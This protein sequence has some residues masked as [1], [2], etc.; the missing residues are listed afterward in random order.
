[1]YTYIQKKKLFLLFVIH[2]VYSY[3]E[4]NFIFMYQTLVSYLQFYIIYIKISA[5]GKREE[6]CFSAVSLP[7][8]IIPAIL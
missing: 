5:T 1:M 7:H 3:F 6:T 8:Q 4:T 2:N